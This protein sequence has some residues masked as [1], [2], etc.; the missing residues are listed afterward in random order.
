MTLTIDE[1][2][3][4]TAHFSKY[5]AADGNGVRIV[6]T[7]EGR[8]FTPQPG[9]HRAEPVSYL[10][11]EGNLLAALTGQQRGEGKARWCD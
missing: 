8:L 5:I 7:H 6:S 2:I 9:H 3:F 4:A 10:D 1:K 11:R